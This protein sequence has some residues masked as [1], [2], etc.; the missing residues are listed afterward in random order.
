[1]TIEDALRP[2]LF[3]NWLSGYPDLAIGIP[4]QSAACPLAIYLRETLS[5]DAVTVSR[6]EIKCHGATLPLPPWAAQFV[7]TVDAQTAALTGFEAQNVLKFA[8]ER[9]QRAP[10]PR[11]RI[12]RRLALSLANP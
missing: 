2:D 11:M 12:L 1:M 10:T 3:A 4:G 8:L 9:A 7:K 6:T 5:L